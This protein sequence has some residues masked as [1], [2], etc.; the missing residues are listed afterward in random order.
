VNGPVSTTRKPTGAVP[1]TVALRPGIAWPDWSAVP[2]PAARGALAAILAAKGLGGYVDLDP[3]EDRVWTTTL[4]LWRREGHAPAAGDIAGESGLAAAEVDAVLAALAGRDRLVLDPAT[5]DIV[6]AYPFSARA[7]GHEVRFDDRTLDTHTLNAMCAI[8]ALGAGAMYQGDVAVASTCR[9]CEAPIRI[10]TR[11]LGQAL[12]GVDPTGAVVWAG[13]HH[14]GCS[15]TSLCT[16][17]LFFCSAAHLE[18]WREKH[19]GP[20]GRL[21]SVDEAMQVGKALFGPVL[22]PAPRG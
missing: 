12:A 17:I 8:D 5:G 3:R 20:D 1:L 6:G 16:T 15:A 9:E 14:D 18:A 7:T 11:D 2:A 10:E 13:I 21:L 4:R 22:A 19:R